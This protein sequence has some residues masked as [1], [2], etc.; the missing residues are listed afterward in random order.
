MW[1]GTKE[2]KWLWGGRERR[3]R[4]AA[5]MMLWVNIQMFSTTPKIPKTV[6]TH[7]LRQNHLAFLFLFQAVT[8]Q[9]TARPR[10]TVAGVTLSIKIRMSST[11]TVYASLIPAGKSYF[12]PMSYSLGKRSATVH[13]SKAVDSPGLAQRHLV[14][15][16]TWAKSS[17]LM[18]YRYFCEMSIKS[19]ALTLMQS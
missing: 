8:E 1:S 2:E 18:N 17:K 9:K 3:E 19:E 16:R 15:L 6:K 13:S 4:N 7:S 12:L 11:H 5:T 14:A 10:C